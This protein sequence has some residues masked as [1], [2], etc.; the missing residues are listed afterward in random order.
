[1]DL[2][3][4]KQTDTATIELKLP[5]ADET[6]LIN[7]DKT[8]MTI[9][10]YGSFSETYRTVIDAQQDRRIKKASRSGGKATFSAD[11]IRQNRLE[12]VLACVKSW[13][14]TMGGACP[15]CTPEE[16]KRVV[17]EYPFI[18]MQIEMAI[19]TPDHFLQTS[20]GN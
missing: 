19:E 13:N 15:P 5:D 20:S 7:P 3:N 4:I 9:E 14:I 11:D 8:P 18:R 17:L 16:V 2:A 10:V 1:M 6:P 12:L